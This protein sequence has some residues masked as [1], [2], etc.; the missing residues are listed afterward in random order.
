VAKKSA[1]KP[2]KF[3]SRELSLS[4]LFELLMPMSRGEMPMSIL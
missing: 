2:Y 4:F 1:P 3:L